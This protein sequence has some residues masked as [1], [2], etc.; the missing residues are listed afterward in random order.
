[1]PL[2]AEPWMASGG[3]RG[4]ADNTTS[5]VVALLLLVAVVVLGYGLFVPS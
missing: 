4:V 2:R 5:T 1:M 3:L